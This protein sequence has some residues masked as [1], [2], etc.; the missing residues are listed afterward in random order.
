MVLLVVLSS[1]MDINT[2]YKQLRELE[3]EKNDGLAVIQALQQRRGKLF[4]LCLIFFIFL[5][6]ILFAFTCN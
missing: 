4:F 1:L 6:K 5:K 3:Q 2:L